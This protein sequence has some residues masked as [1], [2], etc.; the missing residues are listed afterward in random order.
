MNPKSQRLSRE[1]LALSPHW[2][3]LS[4]GRLFSLKRFF[5]NLLGGKNI[6]LSHLPVPV[7]WDNPSQFIFTSANYSWSVL[8]CDQMPRGRTKMPLPGLSEWDVSLFNLPANWESLQLEDSKEAPV[9]ERLNSLGL[10]NSNSHPA[11]TQATGCQ[12]PLDMGWCTSNSDIYHKAECMTRF[13]ESPS[14][15][16]H[17]GGIL[18]VDTVP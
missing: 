13:R 8:S 12:T 15:H 10:S 1:I 17:P 3:S 14:F 6:R 7:P 16:F 5:F 9:E 2:W 4:Q 11:K 18:W